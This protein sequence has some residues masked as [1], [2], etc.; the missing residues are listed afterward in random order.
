MQFPQHF[1]RQRFHVPLG[2]SRV[3]GDEVRDQLIGQTL[4]AAN[5]VEIR[6][7]L[8]EQRERR[9]AHQLQY[10]LLGVLGRHFE[11][12][13]GVVFEHRFQIGRPVEQVVTDAA[14]DKGF[15]DPFDG[16]DFFIQSQ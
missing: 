7:E 10:A 15:F 16:A 3:R 9:F 13:R 8:F 2:A 4:P 11:P 14:A 1:L 6:V 5:A 12:S